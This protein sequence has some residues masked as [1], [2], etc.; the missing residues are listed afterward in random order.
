MTRERTKTIAVKAPP[1]DVFE[2]ITSADFH[3][4][5][6]RPTPPYVFMPLGVGATRKGNRATSGGPCGPYARG[7]PPSSTTWETTVTEVVE[8]QRLSLETHIVCHVNP[9]ATAKFQR[10]SDLVM[11]ITYEIEPTERG[12]QVRLTERIDGS[13]PGM[14][15]VRIRPWPS[16]SLLSVRRRLKGAKGARWG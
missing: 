14:S 2:A 1:A 11:A 6:V 5:G 12:S 10:K 4:P 8:S 9:A 16:P 7:W 15:L 13:I 3:R